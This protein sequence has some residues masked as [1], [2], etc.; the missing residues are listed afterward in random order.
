VSRDIPQDTAARTTYA[1]RV[2]DLHL[3]PLE[4]LIVK[5]ELEV[6]MSM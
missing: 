5:K 2:K 3:S 4:E 1:D 6:V